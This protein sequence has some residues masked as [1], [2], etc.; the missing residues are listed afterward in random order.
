MS[1]LLF[2]S[3]FEYRLFLIVVIIANYVVVISHNDVLSLRA[4]IAPLLQGQT[5]MV[6][7]DASLIDNIEFLGA[8]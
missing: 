1:L 4:A 3:L 8:M 2:V 7:V 5:A 6:P